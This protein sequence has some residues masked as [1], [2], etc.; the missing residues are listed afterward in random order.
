MKILLICSPR[1]GSTSLVNSLSKTLNITKIN[2]PDVYEY[3][4]NKS[5]IDHIISKKDIIVRMN[6]NHEVGY[7]L[8]EFVNFFDHVILLTRRNRNE[9]FK[10]FVN[11]YYKE[12]II[13]NGVHTKYTYD[14]IP[15]QLKTKLKS[16]INWILLLSGVDKIKKLSIDINNP[17]L[18][19][20]DLYYGDNVE[21]IN[22]K[23]SNLNI[24][25]F[26]S[27]ISQT[28]KLRI[29]SKEKSLI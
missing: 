19:Y 17:I 14:E 29:S 5:L 23:I 27:T 11:L 9:H 15:T 10:S 12:I 6:P 20:E 28:K 26:K 7:D 13:K 24:D 4:K 25:L 16:D 8:K 1:S 22:S 21:H 18:Y 3:P 2:I